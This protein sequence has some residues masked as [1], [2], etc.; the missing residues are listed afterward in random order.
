M[1]VATQL[2]HRQSLD[3]IYLYTWSETFEPIEK[4]S[5][6]TFKKYWTFEI[7]HNQ[8]DSHLQY[9]LHFGVSV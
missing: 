3:D 5:A 7:K 9:E 6:G 1:E 8:F 4:I 2:S